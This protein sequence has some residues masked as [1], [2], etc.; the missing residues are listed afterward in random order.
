MINNYFFF[1]YNIKNLYTLIF[2]SIKDI[3]K[4]ANS[5]AYK[6]LFKNA[7][8]KIFILIVINF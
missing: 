7:I 6:N 2:K 8:Y 3:K 4:L 1:R 5:V